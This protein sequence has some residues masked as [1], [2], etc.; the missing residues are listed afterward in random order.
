MD[1]HTLVA[2]LD[3]YDVRGI[4]KRWFTSYLKKRQYLTL[5]DQKSKM[6]MIQTQ[7]LQGSVLGLLLFLVYINDLHKYIKHIKPYHF[8]DDTNILQSNKFLTELEKSM[9]TDPKRLS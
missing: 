4:F 2:K 9:N 8:T 5:N 3:Q 7:V 6:K 1:H